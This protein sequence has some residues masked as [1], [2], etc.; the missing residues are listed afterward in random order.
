MRWLIVL[1]V[2]FFLAGISE[3]ALAQPDSSNARQTAQAT[4]QHSTNAKPSNGYYPYHNR[5]A[6]GHG[7]PLNCGYPPTYS[8]YGYGYLDQYGYY[9]PYYSW[10]ATNDWYD[11]WYQD[12]HKDWNSWWNDY[13]AVYRYVDS[14]GYYNRYYDWHTDASWF[15]DWYGEANSVEGGWFDWF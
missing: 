14:Y 10:T 1:L 8:L 6:F 5:R 11:D 12:A 2:A 15:S 4:Q 13:E 9:N 3:V 7:H